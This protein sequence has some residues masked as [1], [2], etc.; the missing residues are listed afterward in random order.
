[1]TTKEIINRLLDLAYAVKETNK[2]Q[3][4]FVME[5]IADIIREEIER[6]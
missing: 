6:A 2:E 4:K 5:L 1:M 3:F